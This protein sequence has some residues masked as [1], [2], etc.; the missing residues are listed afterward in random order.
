MKC[1]RCGFVSFDDL[2]H[3]KKCGAQLKETS[4]P[5]QEVNSSQPEQYAVSSDAYGAALPPHWH[6]TIQ[7]IKRELEAIEGGA[8]DKAS[9]ANKSPTP[10]AENDPIPTAGYDE[11]ILPPCCG[12]KK[13][14]FYLRLLAYLIDCALLYSAT[15]TVLLAG[16]FVLRSS[17]QNLAQTD[18][19]TLLRL[20]ITPYLIISTVLELFYFIYCYAVTGQTIGKWIC[21][22]KVV[23]ADGTVLGFKRAFV[24]WLGYLVSRFFLYGGFIWIAFSREKQGWHDKMA[25][26]YVIRV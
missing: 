23:R 15:L 22:L 4:E 6:N 5:G 8:V 20:L 3:C 21:G 13:G 19:L 10:G 14:G 25:G 17:A 9:A 16:F 18:T 7:T 2:T 26:S 1:P 24:R 11:N 12:A